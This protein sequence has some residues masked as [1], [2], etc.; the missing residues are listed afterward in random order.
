MSPPDDRVAL[1]W[2]TRDQSAGAG[3]IVAGLTVVQRAARQL[4]AMGFG[5]IILATDGQCPLPMETAG[6]EQRTITGETTLE[7]LRAELRP[8]AE[9]HADVVYPKN[10]Q[11]EDGLRVT[12]D[13]SRQK[14]EDAVF[15]TL[16][17][18]D[19]GI[20]ARWLNKPLSTRITRYVLCHLPCTPNQVTLLALVVGL[21]G[22]AFVGLGGYTN[23]ALGFFLLHVQSVLDGCDG[24]LARVRFQQSPTGEWFDTIA[25]DG[26][27]L[28]LVPATGVGLWRATGN[29]LWL[30]A[31]FSGALMLGAYMIVA[32]RKLLR[33]RLGGD[34]L[35]ISWWFMAGRDLKTQPDWGGRGGV[36]LL[37]QAGRKDFMFFGCFVFALLGWV[38]VILICWTAMATTNFAVAMGQT[39]HDLRHQAATR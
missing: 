28:L 35:K 39:I 31:G 8:A 27:N 6:L 38:P 13:D 9:V 29:P 34:P 7:S 25:D 10:R 16:F 1:L 26:L 12:D 18:A 5:R 17:R 11:L 36:W 21:V 19:L 2:A 23:A 3:R 30:C 33:G 22:V 37:R 14:A 20:V 4:R 24:E 15:A 32:Y